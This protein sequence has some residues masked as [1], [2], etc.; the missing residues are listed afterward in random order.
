MDPKEKKEL[1]ESDIKAKFI[2]PA[3]VSAGWDEMT[4]I[5]REVT[6]TPGP[7]V[8]PEPVEGLITQHLYLWTAAIKRRSTAGRG[9]S[10][11]IELYGI[12]KL[13]ELIL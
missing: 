8:R 9:S 11:K 2:T 7:A 5:R 10:S 1:S 3:I 4:Q 13:R 12:K 6:L